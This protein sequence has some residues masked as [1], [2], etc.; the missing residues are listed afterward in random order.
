MESVPLVPHSSFVKVGKV[1][2]QERCLGCDAARRFVKH[3]LL[4]EV[5]AQRFKAGLQ[6][7]KK[8]CVR[9]HVCVCVRKQIRE[10]V[11]CALVVPAV[12]R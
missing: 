11:Q 6:R 1:R 5:D 4:R 9:V 8:V 7:E 10:I 3:R 12:N 2:V